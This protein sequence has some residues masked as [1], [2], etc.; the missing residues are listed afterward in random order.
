MRLFFVYINKD[1]HLDAENMRKSEL[2]SSIEPSKNLLP[3]IMRRIRREQKM[4]LV[5]KAVFYFIGLS[6]SMSA[7]VF[8]FQ[9][10]QIGFAK[11]GFWQFFSLLFTDFK[12][13]LS[14]WQNFIFSLLETAPVMEVIMFFSSALIFFYLLKLLASDIKVARGGSLA[15]KHYGH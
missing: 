14:F 11:S 1:Y 7:I 5:K 8:S 4:S 9:R 12:T 2:K 15:I 13:V 3:K 6:S 10:A